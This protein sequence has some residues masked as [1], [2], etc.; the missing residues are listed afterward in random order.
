MTLPRSGELD[1]VRHQAVI[2]AGNACIEWFID[3]N[4]CHFCNPNQILQHEEHC[5]LRVYFNL[6]ARYR[7]A[8]AASS[9]GGRS[10]G[11]VG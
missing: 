2:D 11:G 8:Q 9:G 3:T 1:A 7:S 5:P 6:L 10:P 4:D